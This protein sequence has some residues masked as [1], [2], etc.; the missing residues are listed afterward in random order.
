MAGDKIVDCSRNGNSEKI[1]E[2]GDLN[3]NLNLED[4][5]AESLEYIPC[6]EFQFS[7]SSFL[8]SRLC[9]HCFMHISQD[10][11]CVLTIKYFW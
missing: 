11:S 5:F 1:S 8:I 4:E 2:N 9:L 3:I 7:A 6:P 10:D